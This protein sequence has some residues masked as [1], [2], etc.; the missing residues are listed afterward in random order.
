MEPI[1]RPQLWL[2]RPNF[3]KMVFAEN[4]NRER[5][6]KFYTGVPTSHDQFRSRPVVGAVPWV[7]TL[8]RHVEK[9]PVVGA[10]PWVIT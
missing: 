9:R 10:V 2:F 1:S 4:A 8:A 6:E 3:F 7:F 5:V